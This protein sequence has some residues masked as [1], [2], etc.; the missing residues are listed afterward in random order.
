MHGR[1]GWRRCG[2]HARTV[3][4]LP[5]DRELLAGGAGCG[6][7]VRTIDT[8][9]HG[10]EPLAGGAGAGAGEEEP[11]ADAA[12]DEEVEREGATLV[13]AST[14]S[15]YLASSSRQRRTWP[16]ATSSDMA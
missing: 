2:A 4:A 14:T 11:S 10:R 8:L 16:P 1:H 12:A 13:G 5:R 7:H 9:P 15:M 3:N 6:A